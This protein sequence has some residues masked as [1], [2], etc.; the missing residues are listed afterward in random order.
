MDKSIVSVLR[1][2]QRRGWFVSHSTTVNVIFLKYSQADHGPT[3][4]P[5]SHPARLHKFVNS[6]ASDLV[7]LSKETIKCS[8]HPSF[9]A[10]DNAANL[11]LAQ[12]SK[13]SRRAA[14]MSRHKVGSTDT[15][16]IHPRPTCSPAWP[17]IRSAQSLPCNPWRED[18]MMTRRFR[19]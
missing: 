14:H 19:G 15:P 16:Y 3:P 10:Q 4:R 1:A 11:A 8:M 9:V 12:H 13:A 5:F 7:G 6:T 17:P 2:K 18:V